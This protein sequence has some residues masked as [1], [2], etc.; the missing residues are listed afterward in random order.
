MLF[1]SNVLMA[2][3]QRLYKVNGKDLVHTIGQM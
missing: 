2:Q 1:M 3:Q